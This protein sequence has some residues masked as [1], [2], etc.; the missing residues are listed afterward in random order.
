MYRDKTLGVIAGAGPFAGNNLIQKILEQTE[1]F[2]DQDHLTI[3]GWFQPNTILDR[4]EFLLGNWQDNPGYAIAAQALAL[5]KAGAEVI[6][7]PCNTAHAPPIFNV[8]Q[9]ELNHAGAGAL[10]LNMIEETAAF[11]REQFPDINILGVLSTTGAYRT[12]LYPYFLENSGIE[13]VSLGEDIQNTLIHTAIYD[14]DYGIK[15]IGKAHPRARQQLLEGIKHLVSQGA[16]AIIMGC[17]EI[18][19]AFPESEVEGIPLI[20]PTLALARALIHHASPDKLKPWL[21]SGKQPDTP[22][23]S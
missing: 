12:R 11:I 7:I 1:A 5:E 20:D 21:A 18:P 15:A 9:S 8:I 6:A 23:P 14:P 2:V 4:T 19:L 16:E 17:S 13:V 22:P 10:F 3:I